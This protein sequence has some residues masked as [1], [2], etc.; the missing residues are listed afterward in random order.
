MSEQTDGEREQ[1]F[2]P[3]QQEDV[4]GKD[5]ERALENLR[6]FAE[7]DV[8]EITSLDELAFQM[9]FV[10]KGL[11]AVVLSSGEIQ[12]TKFDYEHPAR[13]EVKAIDRVHVIRKPVAGGAEIF[14]SAEK[15]KAYLQQYIMEGD[16]QLSNFTA[17]VP[18]DE[19]I[20]VSDDPFQN[21]MI[22][23]AVDWRDGKTVSYYPAKEPSNQDVQRGYARVVQDGVKNVLAVAKPPALLPPGLT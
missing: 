3:P 15:G 16:N 11:R 4:T 9:R 7:K 21:T 6:R 14:V 19:E 2:G 18:I 13:G 5:Y 23:H 12:E 20:L 22:A 17:T 8:N 1:S 10:S